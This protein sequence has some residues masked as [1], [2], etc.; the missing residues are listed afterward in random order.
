MLILHFFG[1]GG[2][3][4][5]LLVWSLRFCNVSLHITGQLIEVLEVTEKEYPWEVDSF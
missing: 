2:I 5:K 4:T 1:L 3:D